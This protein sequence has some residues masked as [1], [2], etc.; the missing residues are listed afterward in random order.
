MGVS[1]LIPTSIAGVIVAIL[2]AHSALTDMFLG[3]A[4]AENAATA[5]IAMVLGAVCAVFLF[6]YLL[7]P[8]LFR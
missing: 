6:S 8:V 2:G 4:V 1:V 7:N 5:V 3:K